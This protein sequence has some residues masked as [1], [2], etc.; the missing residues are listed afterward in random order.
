M[1]QRACRIGRWGCRRPRGG[2]R[3]ALRRG[4]APPI[5]RSRSSL[6]I[7][8]TPLGCRI[9]SRPASTCTSAPSAAESV[10]A[11]PYIGSVMLQRC[12]AL[13]PLAAPAT[14]AGNASLRSRAAAP[15]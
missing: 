1:R 4:G 2:G 11:S 9:G 8:S 6:N 10:P 3:E 5:D 14:K 7:S 13:Q 12:A 15:R